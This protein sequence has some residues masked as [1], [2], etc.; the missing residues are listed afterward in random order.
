MNERIWEIFIGLRDHVERHPE[1]VQ[2][3]GETYLFKLHDPEA[4]WFVDLKNGRGAVSQ[5]GAGADHVLALDGRAFINAVS[6]EHHLPPHLLFLAELDPAAV[7]AAAAR[8]RAAGQ[9]PD[10]APSETVSTPVR[11]PQ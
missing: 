7:K 9:G 8:A 6:G 5:G 3:F 2:R 1:L 11:R 10:I 4:T